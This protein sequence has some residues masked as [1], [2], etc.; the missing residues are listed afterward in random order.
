MVCCG[1]TTAA[2]VVRQ[3]SRIN[4]Q[5]VP[6]NLGDVGAPV[7]ADEAGN[8]WLCDIRGPIQD[9]YNVWRDGKVV[10]RV[11][12]PHADRNTF[13]FSDQPGSVYA[14]TISG[15]Q[16]LVAD[17]PTFD[18]YRLERLY[19]LEGISGQSLSR[20]YSKHGY[21][22]TLTALDTRTAPYYYL[23]L[24]KLPGSTLDGMTTH[25]GAGVPGTVPSLSTPA[26]HVQECD[27]TEF[28]KPVLPNQQTDVENLKRVIKETVKPKSA[29]RQ[30]SNAD[31]EALLRWSKP[32]NGLIARIEYVWAKSVFFVRLKN[33]SDRPLVVPTANSSS[34]GD[35]GLFDVYTQQG[36]SPW[37]RITHTDRFDRYFPA[38]WK[39]ESKV[40][41]SS[42]SQ[43]QG[44]RGRQPIDR[45][46][47]TLEPDEDCIAMVTGS[48]KKEGTGEPKTVKVVLRQPNAST[49]GRWS[50]VLETP[51]RPMLLSPDQDL[52]LRGTVPF[53]VHFP[54]LSHDY[55]GF[56]NRSP[57][58]SLVEQLHGSNQPLISILT[59]YEPAGVR[60]EFERR[61]QAERKMPMKLLLASAAAVAGSEEAATLFLNTMKDTDYRAV[62]NLHYALWATYR[63][64]TSRLPDGK[65]E[66]PPTWLEELFLA[67]LSDHRAVTGMEQTNFRKGTSFTV[68]SCATEKLVF[69]L[70]G[71]RCRKAVPLLVERVKRR[72]ADW[73]TLHA[74]G[75]IGDP[76]AVSALI[77][78]VKEAYFNEQLYEQAVYALGKLKARD[79]V[80]ALLQDIEY[81]V[82][83]DALAEIGDS[84]AV[85]AIQQLVTTKGQIIR[86]EKSVSPEHD[87][88]RFHAAKVALCY[89]DAKDGVVQL[90]KMLDDPTLTRSQ[91]YDV[92][93]RLGEWSDPRTVPYLVRIIKTEPDFHIVSLAITGLVKL[94]NR[95]AVE[96]LIDCFD[97]TFKP[98]DLG[99]G[100]RVTPATC[101]NR[102]AQGLQ[103][104]TGQSFGADKQLWLRWLTEEGSKT[105]K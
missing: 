25:D 102:I 33:V 54:P 14:W 48:S 17:G 37:Q 78:G 98:Q 89:F 53:P 13:L 83:I 40:S 45:P 42:R 11:Q 74:L 15:L 51:P 85:P 66:Q 96:G 61:M 22:V 58:T 87:V 31:V 50:G 93:F 82:C 81:V 55:S 77:Q 29:E 46:A 99:K 71:A 39:T 28:I 97:V 103:R 12:I 72:E 52:G 101:R 9:T 24:I 63:N 88:E 3:R 34:E 47:V 4:G 2:S 1:S 19:P 105:L 32:V 64:C 76:R 100:E 49:A 75:E 92:V 35:D 57:D 68:S 6:Q 56:M 44:A 8:V 30:P 36:S 104:I 41:Q 90:A 43:E 7:L 60:T 67:A 94:Q 10:Q 16:H 5:S 73:H 26:R 21:L 91:R 23:Y 84:R 62:V 65:R 18:K 95:A 70:E 59:I 79:A 38:P 86:N 20:A 69:A 27:I 80:P